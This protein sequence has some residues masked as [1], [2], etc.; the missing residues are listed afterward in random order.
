MFGF[1]RMLKK[2]WLSHV[3]FASSRKPLGAWTC[4]SNDKTL[5][6]C[7][8]NNLCLISIRLYRFFCFV[9][10]SHKWTLSTFVMYQGDEVVNNLSRY[11]VA[12]Y[13]LDVGCRWYTFSESKLNKHLHL[14]SLLAYFVCLAFAKTGLP[15]MSICEQSKMQF[16]Y[17]LAFF[18]CLLHSWFLEAWF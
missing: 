6:K 13:S 4:K 10:F 17:K 18:I 5:F 1:C 7:R 15:K 3:G 12:Y 2:T 16:N 8:T 14:R 9:C 11:V